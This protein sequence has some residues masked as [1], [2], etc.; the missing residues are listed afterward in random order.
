MRMGW[1]TVILLYFYSKGFF[2]SKVLKFNPYCEQARMGAILGLVVTCLWCALFF[3]L[4]L[5]MPW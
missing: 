3:R 5:T 2:C 4:N 1:Q